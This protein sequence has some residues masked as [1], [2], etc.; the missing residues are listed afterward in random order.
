MNTPN[1]LLPQGTLPPR[2]RS[3]LFFKVLLV[4]AVHVVVFGG[5]LMQGC[6]PTPSADKT[7]P[8]DSTSASTAPM[9]QPGGDLPPVTPT[10]PPTSPT[11]PPGTPLPGTPPPLTPTPIAITQPPA[12]PPTAPPTTTGGSVYVVAHGDILASIAKKNGV[13]LKALEEA[14]PGVDPKKLK[15][16]QKLQI[17]AGATAASTDAAKPGADAAA[18]ASGDSTLYVVK[19]GDSLTKIAKAH[20]TSIKTIEALNDMKT[21][22]IKAGQKLKVPVMKVASAEAAA[23]AA[24]PAVPAPV[25]PPPSAP[26]AGPGAPGSTGRMN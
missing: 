2:E 18:A 25:T 4:I 19:S 1:P 23:P 5:I 7:K 3:T 9:S 22:N 20:N 13:T 24:A 12:P 15:I 26:P 17:P 6:K 21:A 10:P 8:D 14:N 16:G 11:T